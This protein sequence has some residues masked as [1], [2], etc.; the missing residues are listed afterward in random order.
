MGFNR[1]IVTPQYLVAAGAHT[2]NS[3]NYIPNKDTWERL[4]VEENE[5]LWNRYA[6]VVISL[7]D[8][9]KSEYSVIQADLIQANLTWNDF[10]KLDI[11]YIG[12]TTPIPTFA[13]D[14][15]TELYNGYGFYI[16]QVK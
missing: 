15:V 16:Y 8:N 11:K 7:T 12:T 9:D 5:E 3:V 1:F 4:G 6:H 10:E 14:K 13:K 2:V